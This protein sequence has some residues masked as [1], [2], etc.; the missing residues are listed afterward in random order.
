[1]EI[2]NIFIEKL[3]LHIPKL[4]YH[5]LESLSYFSWYFYKKIRISDYA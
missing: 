2:K 5:F 4:L 3:I 1:M